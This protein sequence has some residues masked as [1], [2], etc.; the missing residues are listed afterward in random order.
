TAQASVVIVQVGQSGPP[1]KPRAGFTRGE[2]G[3]GAAGKNEKRRGVN[4]IPPPPIPYI[5]ADVRSGP[6]VRCRDWRRIGRRRQISRQGNPSGG[7]CRNN[8]NQSSRNKAH[9]HPT[10]SVQYRI[11]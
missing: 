1:P 4:G 9:Q 2:S 7:N 6:V 11:K 8:S 3:Q 5:P 10:F